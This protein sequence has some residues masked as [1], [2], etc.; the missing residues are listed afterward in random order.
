MSVPFGDTDSE[1]A[2]A[3]EASIG[4]PERTRHSADDLTSLEQGLGVSF[5]DRDL[6]RLALVHS[7][8]LNENL[9][10]FAESN[11][12]LEFLGDALIGLV[13]AH[14]VYGAY[15][16]MPEGELTALRSALVRG[17]T[18]ARVADSLHLGRYLVLGVG[19]E[20]S[21]GRERPSNLAAAFEAVAGA[22]L[23]DQGYDVA[24]AFVRR[25]L[26]EELSAI[27]SQKAPSNAKSV[28]QELVQGRGEASPTYR[29]VEVT[30][31][32]HARRFTAEVVVSDKVIGRGTGRRKSS[33]EQ[34]AAKE[35]LKALGHDVDV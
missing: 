29:I 24:A 9:G 1:N 11:E 25:A 22:L 18:L 15:T 3:W 6:L 35:A 23:L 13:M 34:E 7:S 12:R 14:Q 2:S 8:Y 26:S 4:G 32:D 20:A 16:D 30:G 28:L 5:R 21:G 10:A 17:D 19:E 33:A 27:E 31:E